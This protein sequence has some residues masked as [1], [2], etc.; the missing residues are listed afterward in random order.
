[1]SQAPARTK[2]R[3]E[4]LGLTQQALATEAGVS[5]Q[6]IRLFDQGW[7]PKR[8]ISPTQLKIE[9]ALARLEEERKATAVA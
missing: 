2:V 7:V 5:I 8:G 1:M 4:R 9:N 6:A 3:R